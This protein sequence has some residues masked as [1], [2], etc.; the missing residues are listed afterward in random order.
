MR[1]ST[2]FSLLLLGWLAACGNKH[3]DLKPISQITTANFYQTADDFRSA[4]NGAYATLQQGGNFGNIYV[5]GD[6][7]SD[8]TSPVAS[9]SVTD[10]DEFD[11]FYL[12]TTNPFLGAW[13]NDGYRGIAR[14]NAI[15]D[16][17][18]G[19]EMNSQLR[20]RYKAETKFIRGVIYFNL[21]RLFGDVPLV[22][23]SVSSPE[24]GYSIGRAPVAEVYAQIEKDLTE[25]EAVL[26][27]TY[28][29]VDVGRATSGAA[30]AFLAKV[31]LTQRKFAQAATKLKEVIDSGVYD[32]LPS[33]AAVFSAAA[34]NH[35]EAVFEIQYRSGGLN[36]GNP[37]PSSFAPEN[38]GN[39]V[40]PFGGDGN[41]QPTI[42]L[43]NAFEPGDQR[44][45]ITVATSYVNAAGVT[46][47]ARFTRK[48]MD[49]PPVKYDNNNNLPVIRYA[50]VLLMYAEALNENGFAA[51][52]DAFR[53]LNAVRR[54]A[55]LP[56]RTATD[57]PSQ[58]AFRLAVEQE[59]RVEL[60]C[61]GHRWFDL[62]RTGR[63]IPVMNAKRTA[64]G[65]RTDLNPNL[66]IFPIPQ[67]QIDINPSLI[68]QNPGY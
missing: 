41:N 36:E 42:D 28:T 55:G 16:Q 37:T 68:R 57:L 18:D 35:R 22:L 9:G 15:L 27:R 66:L 1:Y 45:A 62:V 26:P 53:F 38:S 12:R 67:A 49:S 58:A 50:D 4:V 11:K 2:L 43:E 25:A 32:L 21:V 64:L 46:V 8:D 33:F 20:D 56:E 48:F 31:Y 63:A 13:W 51:N 14:C 6:I 39:A 65:L 29:G 7:P 23:K 30:K 40:I 60:A 44:K 52:G 59:R 54:R 3:L 24:E 47:P 19:V 10:Q 5:A 34:K 61:E 17:I